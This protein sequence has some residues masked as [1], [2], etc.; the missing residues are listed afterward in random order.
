MVARIKQVLLTERL[1]CL[2][3][4]T[5]NSIEIPQNNPIRRLV[6]NFVIKVNAGTTAPSGRKNNHYL[7][8]IKRVRL[9]MGSDDLKFSW[10]AILKKAVDHFE[11][12]V[13]P[14]E[15]GIATPAANASNTYKIQLIADFSTDRK[16]LSTMDALLNAPA[17][18]SVRLFVDWGTAA[19]IFTTKG[20]ASIDTNGGTYCEV[21]MYEAYENGQP[22]GEGE[23]E[24]DQW[25]ANA[26]DL[27]EL[28]DTTHEIKQARQ[29]FDTD[30]GRVK[31]LPAP[32][33]ILTQVYY[34]T[35]NITDGDPEPSSEVLTYF[36]VANVLSAGEPFIVDSWEHW[37]HSLILDYGIKQSDLPDGF[38]YMSWVDQRQ[39]GLRNRD[40]DALQFKYRSA[41]PASG[42][43]NGL[44]TFTRYEPGGV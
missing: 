34:T 41:A 37:V 12:G 35:K 40:P 39:G 36:K 4:G 2:E 23:L 31:I 29:S 7:N 24:L 32:A 38:G 17:L 30:E 10:T 8:A 28:V 3:E 5:T 27:R 11:F 25:L 16:S 15:T 9:I 6:L 1:K 14:Y 13:A 43:S 22:G 44:Q 19:Q 42:K 21:E 33:R 18:S 26:R 20:T